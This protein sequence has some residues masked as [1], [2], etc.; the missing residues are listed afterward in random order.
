VRSVFGGFLA[1]LNER[2]LDRK[3]FNGE[4]GC[5]GERYMFGCIVFHWWEGDDARGSS[6][7]S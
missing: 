7:E 4:V 5:R 3:K 6:Y 2:K 1:E